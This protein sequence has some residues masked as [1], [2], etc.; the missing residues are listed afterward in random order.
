MDESALLAVGILVEELAREQLGATGDL[1]LV[2]GMS[3]SEDEGE[4]SDSTL[5]AVVRRKKRARAMTV[6]G[7][8]SQHHQHLKGVRQ[9][10]KRRRTK[11]SEA[12]S[13][14]PETNPERTGSGFE[15][16]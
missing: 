9:K 10:H 15:N 1:V 11:R 16:G 7:P 13:S 4:V 2:E 12:E 5:P 8:V 6:D 3:S 14:G